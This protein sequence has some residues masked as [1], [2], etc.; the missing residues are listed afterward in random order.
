MP[1][2]KPK[3][4]LPGQAALARKKDALHNGLTLDAIR[5]DG[6]FR[7]AERFSLTQPAMA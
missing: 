1:D 3:V 2:G 4:R 7:L 6:L 5:R